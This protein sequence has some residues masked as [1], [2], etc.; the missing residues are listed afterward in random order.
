MSRY[1]RVSCSRL[2]QS[3]SRTS[4]RLSTFSSSVSP[5]ESLGQH[6]FGCSA[7]W[8]NLEHLQH[9]R[10]D[11]DSQCGYR[12]KKALFLFDSC[13]TSFACCRTWDCSISWQNLLRR[14]PN[15]QTLRSEH[16]ELCSLKDADAL[17]T[18][19][20]FLQELDLCRPD[21]LQCHF[22]APR[23]A[24]IT[25]GALERLADLLHLRRLRL[26]ACEWIDST[27]LRVF[28]NKVITFLSA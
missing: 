21:D 6:G 12:T 28:L 26:S 27:A 3:L 8:L 10:I 20:P 18:N 15:L 7:Q 11:A 9:L 23:H 25:T 4:L 5:C 24:S 2:W 14:L 1:D 17:A 22:R 16:F 19:C 13:L